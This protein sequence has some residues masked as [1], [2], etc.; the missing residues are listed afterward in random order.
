MHWTLGLLIGLSTSVVVATSSSAQEAAAPA[1][2]VV[3]RHGKLS[4]K[5]NRIVDEHGQPVILRGMSLFWSQ[6]G[7]QYYNADCVKWLRDDFECTVV[8]AAMG[9]GAGGY[10]RNPEAEQ[11]KVE[12]VIQSAIDLG[13]YVIVDWHAHE[14]ETAAAQKFFAQIAQKYGQHPNVIYE[15]WNEPMRQDWA[16]VI[17][18]YHEA[19]VATIRQHDPDN[20]IICGTQQWSQL[21]DKAAADPV[22]GTN[23][24]YT[25]HFYAASHKQPLRDK[26]K[27]ALDKGIALMVTEWGTSE[28]TGNGKLDAD[29]TKRW[30]DFMDEHGLSSCNWSVFDKRETSAALM[31]GAPATGG[32]TPEM[33]SPSGKLVREILRTKNA[34]GA[35]AR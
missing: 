11:K 4:V 23:I 34:P 35:P 30:Q 27:A 22:K 18:P 7:G 15:T 21:V 20:L 19:V 24:A 2:T 25:L 29:Q 3:Q 6:W 13:I 9:V 16:T 8:R 26:G 14:P 5:G 17:K 28:A 32:W 33:L 31:P 1:P 12:T 10:L